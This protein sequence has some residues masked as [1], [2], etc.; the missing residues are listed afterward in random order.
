MDKPWK[1]ILAFVGV[2]MA[3]A[4]FGGIFTLRASG[5]RL[6]AER[7][8]DPSVERSKGV[9]VAPPATK[10]APAPGVGAPAQP[11]PVQPPGPRSIGPALMRQ[12]TQRLN[13]DPEQT[14][15]IRPLVNRAAEDLQRLQREHLQ[16][17][18]R[19]TERMYEDVAALLTR[20]QRTQ[21]EMMRQEM[22]E[23]V[24]KERERRG[25]LQAKAGAARPVPPTPPDA[26]NPK[27]R[28]TP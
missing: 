9:T 1:V 12:F 7:G 28:P 5:K 14:K 21:L 16:D 23:R 11:V 20:P 10:S 3:G 24:R 13:P 4:V 27:A 25:E 6:A 22:L 26:A 18:T 2:F 8:A 15:K 17:T 19:V